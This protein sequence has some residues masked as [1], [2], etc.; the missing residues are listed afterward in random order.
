MTYI[1]FLTS[2]YN[3]CLDQYKRLGYA[4]Y[5]ARAMKLETLINN[6]YQPANLAA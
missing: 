3:W 4:S 5:M 6:Y 2:E 1:D